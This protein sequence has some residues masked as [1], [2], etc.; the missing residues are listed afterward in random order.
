[1]MTKDCKSD[2]ELWLAKGE[3]P[4]GKLG[5]VSRASRDA[6]GQRPLGSHNRHIE[7]REGCWSVRSSVPPSRDGARIRRATLS[8]V[9]HRGLVRARADCAR[10]RSRSSWDHTNRCTTRGRCRKCQTARKHWV[11]SGQRLRAR[12]ASAWR[13]P[14]EIAAV[15]C[16]RENPFVRDRRER[17]APTPLRWTAGRRGRFGLRANGNSD[18]RQTM[19]LPRQA[20]GDD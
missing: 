8:S 2:R 19:K 20:A 17:R 3:T 5:T 13:I 11:R 9:R 14:A 1:M 10:E 18:R 6:T 7:I 12:F 4:F 16:P 15:R